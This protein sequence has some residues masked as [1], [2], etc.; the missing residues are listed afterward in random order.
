MRRR[1]RTAAAPRCAGPARQRPASA[2]VH[3]AS[4]GQLRP[5]GRA[6]AAL[7]S[8]LKQAAIF[9]DS[10]ALNERV[11]RRRAALGAGADEADRVLARLADQAAAAAVELE[12]SLGPGDRRRAVAAGSKLEASLTACDPIDRQATNLVVS[13]A[14]PPPCQ[15][16]SFT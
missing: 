16:F 10:A 2:V 14:K 12:T 3:D 9:A 7:V 13:L 4:S 5:A 11:R 6:A 1:T 8:E 15:S